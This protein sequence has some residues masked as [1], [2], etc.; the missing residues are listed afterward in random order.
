MTRPGVKVTLISIFILFGLLISAGA[1]AAINSLGAVNASTREIAT[2]WLPNVQLSNAI[3]RDMATLRIAYRN[4]VLSTMSDAKDAQSQLI[5]STIVSL[6]G[7]VAAYVSNSD[8]E[9]ALVSSLAL[10]VDEYVGKTAKLIDLSRANR[11]EAASDYLTKIETLASQVTQKADALVAINSDGSAMAYDRSQQSY[12]ATRTAMVV[13]AIAAALVLAVSIGF[14]VVGVANPIK[15]ITSSM[16][17]LAAGDTEAAIPFHG[18]SDEIGY[19]ASAVEVFRVSALS[20]T[21]LEQEAREN[22]VQTEADKVAAQQR[23]EADANHRLAVATTGL[24][25]ALTRLAAGDLNC[26]VTDVFSSEFE[27][28]RENFNRSVAQLSVTLE[29]VSH[30]ITAIETG[31]DQITAGTQHLSRRT[32]EQA[33]TL[34]ET[35]AALEQIT[36]NV[37]STSQRTDAARLTTENARKAARESAQVVSHAEDAMRRIEGSSGEISNIISVIDEIA[38]QTNLLALNA[39]VEAARAGEAGKGFA[40]V[41]Q[42][43]RELAQR[44]ARAAKEIKV[45]IERSSGEV[46]GGVHLVR[47]ASAS[48]TIIGDFIVE[49]NGYM[50]EIAKATNEQSTGLK[51]VNT[52]V[53]SIDKTT[54]QNAAMVQEADGSVDVLNEE[55]AR[56]KDVVKHF[57]FSERQSS[58]TDFERDRKGLLRAG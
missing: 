12:Q 13:G 15:R 41:A 14:V 8:E 51:A 52:A 5:D 23:A 36:V 32:A 22:A 7:H 20:K 43:V 29:T 47:E 1:L 31:A 26:T 48:L 19:M 53:N 17:R 49:I 42:E 2:K 28:L 46:F 55:I 50:D 27:G 58:E 37:S 35:A 30:S 33:S 24:A 34:E 9:Q 25:G 45:L 3:V 21:R 16:Q 44:S 54:Q 18:R 10:A 40:V 38:F 56:L 4:H 11:M 57:S 6:K 39:G